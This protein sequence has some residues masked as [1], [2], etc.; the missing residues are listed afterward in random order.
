MA[1]D[2]HTNVKCGLCPIRLSSSTDHGSSS[3]SKEATDAV[4]FRLIRTFRREQQAA[5][6]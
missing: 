4:R 2:E 3:L 6:G 5:R 1:I